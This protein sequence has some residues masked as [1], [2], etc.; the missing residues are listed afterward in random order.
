MANERRADR[1]GDAVNE[2]PQQEWRQVLDDF[3]KLHDECRVT[4]EVRT[5]QGNLTVLRDG[6]FKGI[7]AD[8]PGP[9]DR[10]YVLVGQAAAD[11]FTHAV[12]S[13]KHVWLRGRDRVEIEASDGSKTMVFCQNHQREAA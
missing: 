9:S 4:V 3:S 7:S 1:A 5:Q 13:P 11:D 10:V 2:V 6:P 8:H 12:S